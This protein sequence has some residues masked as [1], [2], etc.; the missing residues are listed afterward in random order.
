MRFSRSTRAVVGLVLGAVTLATPNAAG[1]AADRPYRFPVVGGTRAWAAL[2]THDDMV[3]VTQVPAGTLGRMSTR[4]LVDTA[5]AYPL[6]QDA[7]LFN[8]LQHGFDTMAGR[9]NVMTAVLGRAGAGR[10]LLERYESMRVAGPAAD[11]ETRQLAVRKVEMLLSQQRVLATLSAADLDRTVRAAAAA[12]RAKQSDPFAYGVAGIES[13]AVLAGR[14]DAVRRGE[15]YASNALLRTGVG[16]PALV[17]DAVYR[18]MSATGGIPAG[19]GG[20]G[21][22]D[23]YPSTVYTPRGSAVP[24][25]VMTVEMSTAEINAYHTHVATYYPNATRET[26]ATR[27][28][29]CHSYAWYSQSTSNTRWMDT[30]GDDKYWTDGSYRAYNIMYDGY[31]NYMK[32]SYASDDHSGI[33]D[34]TRGNMWIRSKWGPGPRMYHYYNYS[35]YNASTVNRYHNNPSIL[36]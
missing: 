24:V 12:L 34:R 11:A 23:D 33:E 36:P 26:S 7:L 28:Y 8:D 13:T 21:V 16:T 6:F 22:S 9:S 1:A 27:K 18:A 3:R 5:L 14:A 17:R 25:T 10:E 4:A 31:P 15:S 20:Q 2:A 32:A 30:P 19:V 29:N 35:P